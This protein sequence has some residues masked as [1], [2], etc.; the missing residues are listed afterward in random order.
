MPFSHPY[1]PSYPFFTFSQS[2][3]TT[4]LPMEHMV[5]YTLDLL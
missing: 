1:H 4:L 2:V 5:H 3:I